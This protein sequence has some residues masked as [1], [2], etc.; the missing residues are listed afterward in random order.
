MDIVVTFLILFYLVITI[1]LTFLA[2]EE[3]GRFGTDLFL[4]F[5]FGILGFIASLLLTPIKKEGEM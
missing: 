5:F 4:I 2:D 1:I 3:N